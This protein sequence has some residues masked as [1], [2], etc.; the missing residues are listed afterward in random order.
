MDSKLLAD[1]GTCKLAHHDSGSTRNALLQGLLLSCS[2]A[3]PD[4][5][6]EGGLPPANFLKHSHTNAESFIPRSSKRLLYQLGVL[7]GLLM[8]AACARHHGEVSSHAHL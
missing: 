1:R 3:A 8:E 6:I 7:P 4:I 5:Q 2:A